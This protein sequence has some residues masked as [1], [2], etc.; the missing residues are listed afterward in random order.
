M[1]FYRKLKKQRTTALRSFILNLLNFCPD[2]LSQVF[3]VLHALSYPGSCS[4]VAFV[5]KF[6][7][8]TFQ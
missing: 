7:S 5:I 3:K 8:V 1:T 6:V 4:A 2:C